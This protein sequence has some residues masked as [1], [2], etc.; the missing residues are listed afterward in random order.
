M[1]TMEHTKSRIGESM[2]SGGGMDTSPS[3]M[4]SEQA[5]MVTEKV[6]GSPI[7]AGMVAFGIGFIAGSIIPPSNREREL[8]RSVEPQVERL[9]Q[10]VADTARSA[11]E[12]LAPVV[13]EE[14]NAV[15]DD[16]TEAASA[17]ADTTK[18]EAKATR[19][20]VKSKS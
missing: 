5:E 17:V 3:E 18:R 2:P 14:A 6:E 8:A 10:G 12:H 15:K 11:G 4:M 19:E 1:G 9:A 16:A 13:Q 7:V 20:D